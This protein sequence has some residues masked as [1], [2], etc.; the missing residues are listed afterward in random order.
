ML[1][2]RGPYGWNSSGALAHVTLYI[3][4]GPRPI[5]DPWKFKIENALIAHS[6]YQPAIKKILSCL[7]HSR[8]ECYMRPSV[9]DEVRRRGALQ[10][11]GITVETTIF[12]E[13]HQ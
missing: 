13:N 3:T 1:R 10:F 11:L 6:C 5:P 4:S 12:I 9:A 8:Y 2:L 7:E